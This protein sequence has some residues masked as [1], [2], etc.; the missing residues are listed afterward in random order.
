MSLTASLS[1]C[2]SQAE[3][4]RASLA[5][6]VSE[7]DLRLASEKERLAVE[8]KRLARELA[9]L[10]AAAAA[11]MAAPAAAAPVPAAEVPAEIAAWL[12]KLN[13]GRHGPRLVAEHGLLLVTDCRQVGP[14]S[15]RPLIARRRPVG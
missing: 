14:R 15:P 1:T 10:R 4:E 8:N 9:V 7:K 6:A 11:P 13:L 3:A 12:E 5:S 2:R